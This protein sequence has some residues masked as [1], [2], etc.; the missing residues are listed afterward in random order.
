M[1]PPTTRRNALARAWQG[2]AALLL[3]ALVAGPIYSAQAQTPTFDDEDYEPFQNTWIRTDMPVRDGVVSRTWMWGP[4]D[5]WKIDIEPYAEAPGGERQVIYFDKSRMEVTNP[6]ADEDSIWYVT[7]GLLVVE[8]VSGRV[9]VGDNA[10]EK[11]TPAAVNVA[12]DAKDRN[13]P[14]YDTFGSV[15]NGPARSVGTLITERID[16][17]GNVTNDPTLAAHNVAVGRYAA[18]TDHSVAAPFWSFMNSSGL[19]YRNGSYVNDSLFL[20]PFY[21]TG[22]PIAEAYWAEVQ[23]GGVPTDVL[24]QCFERRCLTYTPENAPGWQVEAGNVGLHYF[25]WRYKDIGAQDDDE[26]PAETPD[27]T[28][29]PTPEPEPEPEPEPVIETDELIFY[30]AANG[31]VNFSEV[32]ANGGTSTQA[33]LLVRKGFTHVVPI[34]FTGDGKKSLL[35]HRESDGYREYWEINENGKFAQVGSP[36]NWT[37]GPWSHLV[38][39]DAD[40]DGNDELLFYRAST[41]GVNFSEVRS[42]GGTKTQAGMN[43]GTGFTHV[44]PIDFDGDGKDAILFHRQSDGYREYWEIT[45]DGKFAQVTNPSKWTGGPWS[46]LLPVD[47]DGDGNE[48]LIFYNADNGNVNYSEVRSTGGT[49]T[50]DTTRVNVGYDHVVAIDSDGDGKDELLFHHEASG[51]REYH[52]ISEDGEIVPVSDGI[53]SGGPWSH[54]VSMDAIEG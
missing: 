16:R 23:V 35:F 51:I 10:F 34:D 28:P 26:S 40:G 30:N 36:S 17:D 25:N 52:E 18:E 46:H 27:P 31:S 20:S 6:S 24:I 13:G 49:K 39:F 32:N 8:L 47:V 37:G 21:A 7:N 3:L 48:E 54:I 11:R 4:K 50:Q 5:Y 41:G 43:A 12:G 22:L 29:T 42:T 45:A 15:L 1:L 44:V 33:T 38:P 2:C 53:W 9:Q 19:V 14:T